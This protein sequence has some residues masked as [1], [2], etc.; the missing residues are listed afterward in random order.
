MTEAPDVPSLLDPDAAADAADAIATALPWLPLLI[1]AL[2]LAAGVILVISG[3]RTLRPAAALAGLVVGGAC[4]WILAEATAVAPGWIGAAV[5]AAIL[6]AM[7]ILLFRLAVA[8]ALGLALAFMA[9]AAVLALD[10]PDTHGLSHTRDAAPQERPG[11][12]DNG[13]VS[14]GP[15]AP[16]PESWL[17]ERPAENGAALTRDP[18]PGL[19]ERLGGLLGDEARD[20]A[21]RRI[22][23]EFERHGGDMARVDAFTAWTAARWADLRARILRLDAAG[24]RTLLAALTGGLLAGLLLGAFCADVAAIIAS[25]AVG[26]ALVLAGLRITLVPLS[27]EPAAATLDRPEILLGAWTLFAAA[28]S[29]VQWTN[30]GRRADRSR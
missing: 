25:A 7:C 8:G 18:D 14:P 16:D 1:G 6:S 15:A 9:G 11:P 27:L 21:R 4:G 12:Q 24:R 19:A 17:D 22:V 3:R 26:S 23:D 5:G 13:D 30:R 20:A 29:V 10:A 28:G 2:M